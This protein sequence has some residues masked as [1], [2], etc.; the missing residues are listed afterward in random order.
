MPA[1]ATALWAVFRGSIKQERA[2]GPWLQL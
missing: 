2:T 1:V